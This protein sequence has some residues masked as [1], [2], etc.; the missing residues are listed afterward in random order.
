MINLRHVVLDYQPKIM[1]QY[2]VF[3]VL[4]V[5]IQVV[6]SFSFPPDTFVKN[7]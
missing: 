3:V 7:I 2:V 4:E 1:Q 6:R 5:A